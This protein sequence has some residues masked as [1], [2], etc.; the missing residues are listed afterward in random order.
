MGIWLHYPNVIPIYVEYTGKADDFKSPSQLISQ[1]LGIIE[2]TPLSECLD[3]L[4]AREK[5]VVFIADEIELIYSD[6]LC[7]AKR[8]EVLDDLAEL[9]SQTTGRCYTFICGS[10]LFMPVLISKNAIHDAQLC[11]RFPMVE[12]AP[13]LN[14]KKFP[15]FRVHRG[16]DLEFDFNVIKKHYKIDEETCNQLYFLAGTN[17]RTIDTIMVKLLSRNLDTES[18]KDGIL[19]HCYPPTLW[20]L[21]AKKTMSQQHEKLI[22]QLSL[23]SVK[24]NYKIISLVFDDI[25]KISSI[26]WIKELKPLGRNE[27]KTIC[28]KFSTSEYEL[29]S[30]VDKGYFSAPPTLD[31]L[32]MSKPID[33]LYYYPQYVNQLP[34][35]RFW[36]WLSNKSTDII[37]DTATDAGEKILHKVIKSTIQFFWR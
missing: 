2:S 9:G 10:S 20:D 6:T 26:S 4:T 34:W 29:S 13:N 24:K 35:K 11:K 22:T 27:I 37:K 32:H 1:R 5:Y 14:G 3:I 19:T 33:L 17:L 12:F 7:R 8:R 23:A 30:L 25:K 15:A 31:Y 28:N 16:H 36:N 21:K 18:I